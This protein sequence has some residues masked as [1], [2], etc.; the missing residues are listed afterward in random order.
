MSLNLGLK[1]DFSNIVKISETE[2]NK[3][4]NE[5]NNKID[6]I[7]KTIPRVV[8]TFIPSSNKAVKTLLHIT[9]TAN[10]SKRVPKIV[11]KGLMGLTEVVVTKNLYKKTHITSKGGKMSKKQKK[12]ENKWYYKN[13][14]FKKKLKEIICK[15]ERKNDKFKKKIKFV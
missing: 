8:K 10:K 5:I 1:Y 12:E 3:G 2:I 9:G 11:T 15:I 13:N 4:K 14:I 6:K 7:Y